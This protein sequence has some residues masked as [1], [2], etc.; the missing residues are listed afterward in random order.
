MEL[1]RYLKGEG[2]GECWSVC[3]LAG[4]VMFSNEPNLLVQ[5]VQKSLSVLDF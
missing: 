4:E 1:A 2:G 3:L 5:E